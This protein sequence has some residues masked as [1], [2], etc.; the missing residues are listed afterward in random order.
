MI[1]L[2]DRLGTPISFGIL[3]E[4]RGCEIGT[5]TCW[6]E[7]YEKGAITFMYEDGRTKEFKLDKIGQEFAKKLQPFQD[8]AQ[9]SYSSTRDMAYEVL[10]SNLLLK[11]NQ[12]A[13]RILEEG[14]EY[15]KRAERDLPGLIQRGIDAVEEN[16]PDEDNIP[17]K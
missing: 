3:Y 17:S 1:K 16:F 2:T 4:D 14:R 12:I 10:N 7:S 8:S 9:E 5:D 11:S 13:Q 15:V 6:I